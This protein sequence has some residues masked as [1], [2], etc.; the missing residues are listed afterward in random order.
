ML[1][2]RCLLRS[3]QPRPNLAPVQIQGDRLQRLGPRELR[4]RLSPTQ[5][6]LPWPRPREH[7][8]M[9]LRI[10]LGQIDANRRYQARLGNQT[11][12]PTLASFL[13]HSTF[14]ARLK[15]ITHL[16]GLFMSYFVLF[17]HSSLLSMPRSWHVL[18]RAPPR[19]SQLRIGHH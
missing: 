1:N 15:G 5:K 10:E 3:S 17:R 16:A 13:P 4:L 12:L 19:R 11:K 18:F 6:R 14:T 2:P 8:G 7:D 9:R